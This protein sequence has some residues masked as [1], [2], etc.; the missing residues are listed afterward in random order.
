MYFVSSFILSPSSVCHGAFSP[1]TLDLR[2]PQ[3]G[4]WGGDLKALASK[5]PQFTNEA[6]KLALQGSVAG[7]I[8]EY[9]ICGKGRRMSMKEDIAFP[10]LF[11]FRPLCRSPC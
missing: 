7:F 11:A 2:I 6:V 9:V 10:V 3:D 8:R 1:D 5:P 4:V